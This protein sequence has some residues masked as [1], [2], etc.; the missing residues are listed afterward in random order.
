MQ[1]IPTK[2]M[3][4][5]AGLGTR[6]R[7]LTNTCPKPLLPL[8]GQPLL[9]YSVQLLQQVGIRHIG[10]NSHHLAEQIEA[11]LQ[12]ARGRYP[13]IRFDL[14]Y[15]PQLLDSGGGLRNAMEQFDFGWDSPLFVLNADNLWHD[16][17]QH[18]CHT[19]AQAWRDSMS[20]LL[21]TADRHTAQQLQEPAGFSHNDAGQLTYHPANTPQ[22]TDP[23]YY[24]S[25]HLVNPMALRDHPIAPFGL[26][27]DFW[28]PEA[29]KG[30]LYGA[31]YQGTW[32]TMSTPTDLSR[33]EHLLAARA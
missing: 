6:M 13:D 8:N 16:F 32:S 28:L 27:K 11:W 3:I 18:P 29:T 31:P 33:T 15:E 20:V 5:T 25:M 7:P 1:S 10:L 9:D 23:W 4:L 24:A 12:G 14:S 26:L 19:L 17:V 30:R 21:L 2:A 22:P